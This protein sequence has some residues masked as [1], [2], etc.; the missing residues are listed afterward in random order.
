MRAVALIVF[1]CLILAGCSH[2]QETETRPIVTT[3]DVPQNPAI[4]ARFTNEI[5]PVMN[6]YSPDQAG[7]TRLTR[8]VDPNLPPD[9]LNGDIG[10][11][12]INMLR[13][14]GYDAKNEF[15]HHRSD[16]KI[17]NV[18]ITAIGSGTATLKLCYKYIHVW[19]RYADDPHNEAPE[20]SEANIELAQVNNVWYLHS[21]TND[22]VVPDC[23]SS[24]A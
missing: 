9:A 21:V 8:I 19:Y 16:P 11:A 12:L 13:G 14:S 15:A 7:M 18:D 3:A 10:T 6:Q 4:I 23:Q 17:A 20:S 1:A 5:W 24:K 22:H 2:I